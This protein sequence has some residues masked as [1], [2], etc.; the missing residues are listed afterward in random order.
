MEYVTLQ[1]IAQLLNYSTRSVYRKLDNI[2]NF[3]NLVNKGVAKKEGSE[4]EGNFNSRRLYKK[5]WILSTFDKKGKITKQQPQNQAAVIF[6]FEVLKAQLEVKDKQL[7]AKDKQIN[8]LHN[9]MELALYRIA[10][11]QKYFHINGIENGPKLTPT[12]EYLNEHPESSLNYEIIEEE[13]NTEEVEQKKETHIN[14]GDS[15]SF[16][17]WLKSMK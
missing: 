13:N 12:R 8:D 6:S 9:N 15:K 17:E 16:S 4:K 7:E 10:E 3:D 11:L 1:E 14:T 2:D 5:D